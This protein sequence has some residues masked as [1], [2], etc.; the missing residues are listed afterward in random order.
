M[1]FI[2][3]FNP[4]RSMYVQEEVEDIVYHLHLLS[5]FIII[6][7]IV[8]DFDHSRFLIAIVIGIGIIVIHI[9]AVEGDGMSILR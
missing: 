6:I 2:Y 1:L 8:D 3:L 9:G 5:F 4:K 7:I